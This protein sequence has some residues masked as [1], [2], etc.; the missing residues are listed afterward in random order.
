VEPGID[1]LVHVSQL[2]HGVKAGD[3]EVA[4]GTSVQGWV[5]EVDRRRSAS[6]CRCAPS[7]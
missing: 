3:E 1:G 6:R 5:R 4:I 2:P 7:R